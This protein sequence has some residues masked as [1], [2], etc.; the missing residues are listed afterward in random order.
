MTRKICPDCNGTGDETCPKH[1]SHPCERCGGKGCI[2]DGSLPWGYEPKPYKPYKPWYVPYYKPE[3]W[4][5]QS[6]MTVK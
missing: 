5:M 3:K 1:G 2:K 4:K 6:Q